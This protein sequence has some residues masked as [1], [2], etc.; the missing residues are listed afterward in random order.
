MQLFHEFANLRVAQRG[1]LPPDQVKFGVPL[2]GADA[3]AINGRRIDRGAFV[4][5]RGSMPFEFHSPDNM[6]LVGVLIDTDMLRGVA[7]CASIDLD[8]AVST[9]RARYSRHCV[10][11]RACKSRR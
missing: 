6:A 9:Q 10:R 3:F 8:D 4:M 11:A 7:D 1:H 5:T 2:A